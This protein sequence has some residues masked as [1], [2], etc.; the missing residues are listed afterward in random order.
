MSTTLVWTTDNPQPGGGTED[1]DLK[2]GDRIAVNVRVASSANHFHVEVRRVT[3]ITFFAPNYF[4]WIDEPFSSSTYAPDATYKYIFPAGPTTEATVTALESLFDTLT[5]ADDAN[6]TRWP[7]VSAEHPTDLTT[8][9]INKAVLGVEVEG[10]SRHW[11][12]TITTPAVPVVAT[13]SVITGGVLV[14]NTL[15]LYAAFIRY[16]VLNTD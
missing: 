8:G 16:S 11:D 6:S 14:A 1:R 12:V 5:P 2:V 3:N 9:R 13:T 15:R 7:I 10:V 4:I